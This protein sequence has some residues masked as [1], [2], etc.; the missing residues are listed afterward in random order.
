MT[1]SKSLLQS[2]CSEA[3][4]KDDN[5]DKIHKIKGVSCLA[6]SRHDEDFGM[7]CEIRSV[8]F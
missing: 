4:S 3:D 1:H 6:N 5:P 7:I 2:D 8:F